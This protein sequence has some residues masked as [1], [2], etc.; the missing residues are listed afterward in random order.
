M[1]CEKHVQSRHAHDCCRF[2]GLI[3]A[4]CSSVLYEQPRL[5][6]MQM[7]YL[8]ERMNVAKER[9][10]GPRFFLGPNRLS[11]ELNDSFQEL[12]YPSDEDEKRVNFRRACHVISGAEGLGLAP[13]IRPRHINH[14]AHLY[15]IAFVAQVRA[16]VVDVRAFRCRF[17]KI[18]CPLCFLFARHS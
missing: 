17:L 5:T 3:S 18:L 15:N 13:L 2:R 14:K 16:V 4:R 10:R 11:Q 12:E 9:S 1:C 7:W 8:V 6:K